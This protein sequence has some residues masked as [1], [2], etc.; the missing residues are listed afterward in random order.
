M[1]MSFSLHTSQALIFVRLLVFIYMNQV[2]N[3]RWIGEFSSVLTMVNGVRQ[4]AVL[5]AIF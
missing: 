5:S 4:G 3:V 2:A 1:L